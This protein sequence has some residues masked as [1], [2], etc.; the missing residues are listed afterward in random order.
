[1]KTAKKTVLVFVLCFIITVS[2]IIPA[3]AL[4][5]YQQKISEFATNIN[6]LVVYDVTNGKALFA[7]N[8]KAHISI[9][10]T[11]KLVTSLVALK[12][13]SPDHVIT[14]GNEIYLVKPNSS[15][16]LIRPGH[17]LKL[18]TLIAAM[19]LPSGNDA[20]YT[21]AVNVARVHSGDSA[22]SGTA[23]VNYFCNLMN[24]YA[25]EL[26]CNNT[27]FV[28]PE[29]WDDPNHFSTAEDMTKFA[30]AAVKN[31][32]ITSI[33]NIHSNK[34]YFYSGENI[35]W[36]NSNE[37]I[38][39]NSPYYYPYAHGLKTGTTYSAGKCL[40]ANAVKD[41]REILILAYG[42]KEEA[43]RFGK[44]RDIFQYIY[45]APTL[46]DVDESGNISAADARLVLRASVNLEEITPILKA[47]GDVN[48]DGKLSSEDA[49]TILR[50]S[51]G[52]ETI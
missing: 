21:V 50:A 41:G 20:A 17:Q 11:T 2:V 6:T 13:L 18:R 22:L 35:T 24:E 37:L 4:T 3:S 10:S 52:L 19:L 31:S 26:G 45:S 8:E 12:Y 16:S 33:A 51:V 23:A 27:Y 44:V 38:N 42:C 43:D 40:V 1:M 39:P 47:R 49:R 25:R 48:K 29:G 28:N 14:V 7:K 34:F 32:I 46:G 36:N 5:E 30:L 9:A 15:L